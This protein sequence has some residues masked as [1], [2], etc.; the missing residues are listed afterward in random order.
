MVDDLCHYRR[1]KRRAAPEASLSESEIIT[2]GHLRS[3]GALRQREGLLPLRPNR[4]LRG[5]FSDP[6]RS[7]PVQSAGA[8]SQV[9]L[10]EEV[11]LYLAAEAM[12]ND[13]DL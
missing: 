10:I 2:S 9:G 7:F 12:G 4:E 8:F 1:P 13:E 6:A 3:L 5:A 11:A